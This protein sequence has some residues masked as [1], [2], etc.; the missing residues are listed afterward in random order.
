MKIQELNLT[1]FGKF[2]DR[3]YKLGDG[4]NLF[5]G[6]N[7]S[8]KTT[9]HMFIQGMLFGMERGRGR[10]AVYDDF[11]RYAPWDNPNHYTGSMTFESDGKTFRLDRNFDRYSKKADLICLDDGE[12]LSVKEGDLH[13]LLGGMEKNIFQNTISVPQDNDQPDRFLETQIRNYASDYFYAGKGGVNMEKALAILEKKK[14][15]LGKQMDE[16]LQERRKEKETLEQ[17]AAYVWREIHNLEQEL[18]RT[19]ELQEA[20]K[21]LRKEEAKKRREQAENKRENHFGKTVKG[22]LALIILWLAVMAAAFVFMP[23]LWNYGITL[24]ILAAGILYFWNGLKSGSATEKTESERI[25]EEISSKED[26]VPMTKLTWELEHIQRDL[27]EKQVEYGNLREQLGELQELGDVYG[28]YQEEEKAIVIAID[29]MKVIAQNMQKQ[30]Q[31]SINQNASEILKQITGGKYQAMFVEDNLHVSL[32]EDGLLIAEEQV[33]RGTRAQIWLALRLAADSILL[34]EE[35]PLIL[36]DA[37]V[38]YDDER[39]E[40]AL[41]WL[42]KTGRQVIIFSCQAREES[43]LKKNGIPYKKHM[44]A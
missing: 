5:Y 1:H 18:D 10:A 17:Q 34:E 33:S 20:Q 12:K 30:M 27:Q 7:E 44:I 8:G 24:V 35:M 6:E 14:K 15:D 29:R 41:R 32:L 26:F 21:K 4:L 43:L 28:G 40:Q 9:T 22:S 25:L 38:F 42:A 39:L 36:D 3:S 37:F 23:K 31:E 19:E 13:M 2:S 16:I 11:S